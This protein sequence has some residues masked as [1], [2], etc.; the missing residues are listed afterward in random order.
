MFFF[1]FIQLFFDII[2]KKNEG[3]YM[4][5]KESKIESDVKSSLPKVKQEENKETSLPIKKEEKSKSTLDNNV[6]FSSIFSVESEENKEKAPSPTNDMPKV[7]NAQPKE[8][9]KEIASLPKEPSTPKKTPNSNSFNGQERLLYEI[10][11]EKEGNPIVVVFFFLFLF[12][13]IVILPFISK[14]LDLSI[15]RSSSPTQTTEEKEDEY[16]YFNKSSVRA[17]LGQLE[18]TN[19]VK[20]KEKDEYFIRFNVTNTDEKPYQFD[21][22]YYIVLYEDE[23]MVY[24]ALIHSYD[25]IGSLGVSEVK[26]TISEKGYN[27]ADRFKIEEINESQY[28]TVKLTE[29]DGDYQVLTCHYNNDEIKYYFLDGKLA[30]LKETFTEERD[31][32]TSYNA[33]LINY[34]NLSLD[35]KKIENFQSTFI[36]DSTS[37]TMI[38]TINHKDIPDATLYNLKTYKFFKYNES[39]EVVSFELE[40]QGYTCS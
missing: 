17:S 31:N 3:I 25:A 12:I 28:P 19:F 33:D 14:K 2:K 7:E 18:F 4:E 15:F 6:D 40:A 38:N 16:Y 26:A 10:K 35:Y 39:K 32:T 5:N 11:P 36:E 29:E 23:T 20:Y 9:N 24:R 13:T 37:F 30:S 27:D 8:E 22:K 34:R 1:F 21:K